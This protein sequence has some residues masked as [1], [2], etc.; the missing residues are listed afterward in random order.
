MPK[1]YRI[2]KR[3]NDRY[4]KMTERDSRLFIIVS[5]Y[6]IIGLIRDFINN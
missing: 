1:I 2:F 6:S 3:K 5:N 4:R